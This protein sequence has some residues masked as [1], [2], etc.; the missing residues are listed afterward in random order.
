MNITFAAIS[1]GAA[2]AAAAISQPYQRTLPALLLVMLGALLAAVA[3]QAEVAVPQGWRLGLGSSVALFA[4]LVAGAHLAL[5]KH[6]YLG[7]LDRVIWA[8]VA[9]VIPVGLLLP[10]PAS[11]HVAE[12]TPAL[13]TH[14]LL[15]MLAWA[16]L[17]LAAMQSI[18][19]T[20]QARHLRRHKKPLMAAPLLELERSTFRLIGLGWLLLI[21]G[22]ATG[23]L[24]VENFF[25]QHLAHKTAF[26]LMA[27]VLFGTLLVGQALRGWR[28]GVALRWIA[29][30][31]LA[32]FVG[33][34]GVKFV[35][36]YVL[37]SHWS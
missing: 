9:L 18:A 17:S 12:L 31:W 22:I 11:T 20:L 25:A 16:V 4:W 5:R 15:S 10:T 19:C 27:A 21:G 6:L 29:A 3:L 34:A 23:F 32:L 1:A 33:Y 37:A 2:F 30:A 24:F 14:I 28:G 26:T 7:G 35:L 13:R 8:V 36:E